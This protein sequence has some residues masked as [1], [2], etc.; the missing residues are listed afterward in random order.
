MRS[1]RRTMSRRGLGYVGLLTLMVT[2]VGAAG[3][4]A[5]E[6]HEGDRAAFGSF[7][8]S[9]WW[10]AMLMTTMGPVAWP[11]TAEGRLLCLLLALYAF[12]IFG[13]ITASLTSWFVGNDQTRRR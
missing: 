7:A 1:L 2:V 9:L 5:F 6:R 12:A 8:S 13:Y 3:M 10:T 11:R 4:N